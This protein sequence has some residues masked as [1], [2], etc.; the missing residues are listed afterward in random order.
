MT[1]TTHFSNYAGLFHKVVLMSGY[2][3]N[4]VAPY[5]EV[6]KH[7]ASKIAQCLGYTGDTDDYVKILK[8]LKRKTSMEIVQCLMMYQTKLPKVN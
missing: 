8:F 4:P 6:N 5:V 7:H 1:R 2:L 3:M